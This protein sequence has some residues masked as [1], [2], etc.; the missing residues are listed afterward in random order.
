MKEYKRALSYK[1][2]IRYKPNTEEKGLIRSP[3]SENC[4]IL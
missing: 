4:K 1:S 2:V 3:T